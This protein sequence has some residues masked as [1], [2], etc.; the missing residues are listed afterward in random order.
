MARRIFRL[1]INIF[2]IT[3]AIFCLVL[4]SIPPVLYYYYRRSIYISVDAVPKEPQTVM[5]L[6]AAVYP[7]ENPSN[8]L[9]DRRDAGVKLYKEKSI[10]KFIVSG[11]KEEDGYNEPNA[12][13]TELISAGIPGDIIIEDGQGFRTFDSCRRAKTEYGVTSLLVI[14]QGFHLPRSLFLCESVGIKT[15]G[16][17][18]TG[19]FSSNH[20]DYY[21]LRE[22]AA[23]YLAVWDV[24]QYRTQ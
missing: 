8:A 22:I 18:S 13:K 1:F 14:S 3:L 15:T 12:M 23:M 24:V 4:I 21:T 2:V 16:L 19:T 10:Q 17:Y 6:G 5:I 9:Q 20:S 7:D 11:A